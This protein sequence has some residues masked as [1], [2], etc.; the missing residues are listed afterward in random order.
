MKIHGAGARVATLLQ[1]EFHV[2]S[3]SHDIHGVTFCH[4]I[5]MRQPTAQHFYFYLLQSKVENDKVTT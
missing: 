1:R 3:L 2:T 5:I 4:M